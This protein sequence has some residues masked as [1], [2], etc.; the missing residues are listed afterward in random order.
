M[1]KLLA[2]TNMMGFAN[3]YRGHHSQTKI[4]RFLRRNNYRSYNCSAQLHPPTWA[5]CTFSSNVCYTW[6]QRY[7][8]FLIL[9]FQKQNQFTI[10]N[11]NLY[12]IMPASLYFQELLSSVVILQWVFTVSRL[13]DLTSEVRAY[14]TLQLCNS[15]N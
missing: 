4:P 3:D 9:L 1:T 7:T 5:L 14:L 15:E 6:S 13:F 11:S 2:K 12:I 10:I 8:V